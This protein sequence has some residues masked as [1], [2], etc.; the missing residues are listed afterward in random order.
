[1]EII[2]K[3]YVLEAQLLILLFE[4]CACHSDFKCTNRSDYADLECNENV[5]PLTG[6]L[7]IP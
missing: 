3:F 1:M 6:N 5:Y 4:H 7:I 2:F